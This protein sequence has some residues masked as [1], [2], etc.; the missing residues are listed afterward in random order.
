MCV[1]FII[2]VIWASGRIVIP[3][4]TGKLDAFYDI[5]KDQITSIFFLSSSD[6]GY[7]YLLQRDVEEL[8]DYL[9][10]L[11][12]R[13]KFWQT[14]ISNTDVEAEIYLRDAS[15]KRIV[16]NIIDENT[17]EIDAHVYI[18]KGGV[19]FDYIRTCFD[20]A[21]DLSYLYNGSTGEK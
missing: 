18:V 20:S 13:S 19:N 4:H 2:S 16:I 3:W 15:G 12:I 5:D 1:L 10:S 9:F 7:I 17:I 14:D 11:Q 8:N 6:E 21:E